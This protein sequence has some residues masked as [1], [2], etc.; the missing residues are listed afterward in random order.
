MPDLGKLPVAALARNCDPAQLEFEHTGEVDDLDLIF[1]QARAETA[2]TFGVNIRRDGFNL[3]VLGPAGAGKETLLRQVIARQTLGEARPDDWCYV[4]NFANPHQPRAL[5]LPAGRGKNLRNDMKSLV[6]ELLAVVPAVF[7]S[8]EYRARGEQLSAEFND[9]REKEFAALAEQASG[10]GIALI[11][12]PTGFTLAPMKDEEVI[13]PEAF[14]ELPVETQRGIEKAIGELQERLAQLL[15]DVQRWHKEHR[16]RVRQLNREVASTTVEREMD[17]LLKSYADLPD[18]TDYLHAVERDLIEN[19]D[20]FRRGSEPAPSPMPLI[21]GDGDRPN[22]RRYQVNLLLDRSEHDGVPVVHEELPTHPNL[23]GRI[24]HIPQLGALVTDFTLIK[25]GALHRANGGYLLLD[26]LKLL[27]QPFA[28]EGLKRALTTRRIRIESLGQLYSIV[29]TTSLEPEPI[30]LDV[31]VVLFGER[32]WYYLL[33]EYDP[34]F[35][36]LFKVAADFEDEVE[37]SPANQALLARL[38][39]TIARRQAMLPFN[40]GAVARLIDERSREVEDSER[41]STNVQGLIDAMAEADHAARRYGAAQVN[42]EHVDTA[43]GSGVERTGRI[44]QKMREMILRGSI[45]VDTAGAAVGQV[46]GLSVHEL[47]G[48]TFGIPTRITARTRPG[49]GEVLDVQR[50]V[51]MGGPIHSKGVLILSNFLAT[52]FSTR[53]PHS[54]RATLVFEQ[55]YGTVDGDSASAAELCALL[56]SLA[57]APIDQSIAIT[58]SVNLA[59]EL[60]VIGAVNQKIEGFFEICRARGLTGKQGVVIPADNVKNLMLRPEV[61][62]AAAKGL[63]DIYAVRSIDAAIELLTGVPAGEPASSG[64]YPDGTINRR[65]ANRLAE[66]ATARAAMAGISPARKFRRTRGSGGLER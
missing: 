48:R 64:Q 61:V 25:A 60:Q 29:S 58:G 62:E 47:G 19:I 14:A 46:N 36:E 55:T 17:E 44:A 63:F 56:S 6:D 15:R 30:P 37:R 7:D 26:V 16:E 41:L 3:Y 65:V 31:K 42:A 45:L 9:R 54:L 21:V 4:N 1:G 53:R 50:E 12:T 39:A 59:G 22:F 11:R 66:F 57:D 34:E 18:V 20:D 23:L 40:R 33:F 51:A 27:A 8:D 24:E 38:I 28:W 2:I 10:K 35:A 49:D 43:I 52:R 32:H 13:T 5:R